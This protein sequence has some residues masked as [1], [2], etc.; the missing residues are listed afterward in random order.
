MKWLRLLLIKIGGIA[1]TAFSLYFFLFSPITL[2][3]NHIHSLAKSTITQIVKQSGD[4]DLGS[5]LLIAKET[6]IEDQA[7]ANLPAKMTFAYSYADLYGISKN[8][9]TE[10]KITATE[11]GLTAHNK[12][13]A[14]IN[15]YLLREINQSL[16]QNKK[17]VLS[18][19]HAYQNGL[20]I[21]IALYL[22]S[23]LLMLFGR[24]IAVLPLLLASLASFGV[25]WLA[26]QTGNQGKLAG[27]LQLNFPNSFKFALGLALFTV[28]LWPILLRRAK[29][30]QI[31]KN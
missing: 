7:I 11:I 24:Y 5:G 2:K 12:M 18:W 1:L 27:N 15:N 23:A 29:R 9:Q 21:I 28:L 26:C 3:I 30:K 20:L 6:G 16:R 17:Q 31:Q 19:L 22:L 10:G 8:Y 4:P 13:Q 25:T 14:L